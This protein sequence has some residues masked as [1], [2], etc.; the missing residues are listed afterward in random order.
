MAAAF[1]REGVIV[2]KRVY[3]VVLS[4]LI[5]CATI[6]AFSVNAAEEKLR[7][8]DD[9]GLVS[10]EV[11]KSLNEELAELSDSRQIDFIVRFVADVFNPEDEE[12]KSYLE[13]IFYDSS[14]D[15]GYGTD[16]GMM[17]LVDEGNRK[18]YVHA[19]GKAE[20]V[21]QRRS[22][23]DKVISA[24]GKHL[25]NEDYEEAVRTFVDES[26]KIYQTLEES[27]TTTQSRTTQRRSTE[28]PKTTYRR[29]GFLA[30]LANLFRG[31]TLLIGLIGAII[32]AGGMFLSHNSKT[33]GAASVYEVNNSFNMEYKEDSFRNKSVTSR[34]IQTSSSSGGGGGSS[35]RSGGS[36]GSGSY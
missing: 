20:A 1:H 27:E 23:I 25:K 22:N 28:Q 6:S 5:L 12:Y 32:I 11:A 7:F 29:N 35:S 36:G 30:F 24:V 33:K 4:I 17:L 15:Y 34:T 10:E 13:E 9:Y 21:F 19:F 8:A 14:A 18:I 26:Y 16:S 3:T 31:K 2:S